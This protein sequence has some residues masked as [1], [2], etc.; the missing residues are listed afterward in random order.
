MAG[1][2]P[3]VVTRSPPTSMLLN[4]LIWV[5]W[6]LDFAFWLITLV[7]PPNLIKFLTCEGLHSF[8]QAK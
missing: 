1:S 3:F 2:S 4:P 8:E 6:I 7:W 5:L